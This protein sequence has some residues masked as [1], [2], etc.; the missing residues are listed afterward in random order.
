MLAAIYSETQQWDKLVET[1][2]KI[3]QMQPNNLKG[4]NYLL[5]GTNKKPLESKSIVKPVTSADYINQSLRYYNT[6]EFQKCID[7][8]NSALKTDPNNADAYNN[9]GA[10]Y[11]Q[12]AEW[13]KAIDACSKALQLNPAHRLAKGNL[14]FAKSELNKKTQ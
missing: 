5:I 11:N 3:L 9:I 8:C 12:L 14:N 4:K 6:K 13:Q 2:N 7:A 10:A 1:A